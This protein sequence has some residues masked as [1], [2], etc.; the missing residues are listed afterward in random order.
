MFKANKT[1][2][3]SAICVLLAIFLRI[4]YLRANSNLNTKIQT[5]R[6]VDPSAQAFSSQSP[7]S[8]SLKYPSP[9]PS[10]STIDPYE[11]ISKNQK[12]SFTLPNHE[13]R[14]RYDNISDYKDEVKSQAIVRSLRTE[15]ASN[16][17]EVFDI[18]TATTI[19]DAPF[20]WEGTP[21][22]LLGRIPVDANTSDV[23]NLLTS[24]SMKPIYIQKTYLDNFK[25]QAYIVYSKNCYGSCFMMKTYIIPWER[26]I[27]GKI[28]HNLSISLF[29][30]STVIDENDPQTDLVYDNNYLKSLL[31]GQFETKLFPQATQEQMKIQD[32]VVKSIKLI[33]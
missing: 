13:I 19:S 29:V 9:D 5:S 4:I 23:F 15:R 25:L 7:T 11:Y 20:S 26:N 10:L 12:I 27:D 30:G 31:A 22:Y 24:Y 6:Q 33:Y 8:T 2:V 18:D 21:Q 32:A 28:Y 1:I 3:I 14:L 17:S 16:G